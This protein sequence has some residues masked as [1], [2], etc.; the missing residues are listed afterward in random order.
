MFGLGSLLRRRKDVRHSCPPTADPG[1]PAGEVWIFHQP[2]MDKG[3]RDLA[4]LPAM[5][6]GNTLTAEGTAIETGRPTFAAWVR[7]GDTGRPPFFVFAPVEPFGFAQGERV[8]FGARVPP[9]A[10]GDDVFIA[11]FRDFEESREIDEA[12]NAKLRPSRSTP[13]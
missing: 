7:P 11:R 12:V 8:T 6:R 3:Q 13:A 5:I 2:G 1:T 9:D 10:A 4:R